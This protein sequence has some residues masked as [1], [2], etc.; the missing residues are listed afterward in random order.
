MPINT[1]SFA[2]ALWPGVNAWYGAEYAK[3][4]EEYLKLYEKNTSTRNY[5]EDVGQSG[6][7]LAV[8]KEEGS[9]V[10]YDTAR[11][12]F[13]TRY[14]HVTYGL[15]FIITREMYEDGLYDTYAKKRAENLAFSMR[16]TKEI[17]GASVYNKA[18]DATQVGG[19]GVVLLS[20]AHPN[21]AGGT[22]SNRLAVD[23]DLSEAALE[24]ACIDIAD[25]R[26]DRGLLIAVKPK[27]LI[28]PPELE[29]EAARILKTVGRVGTDLNDINALKEMSKFPGGVVVNHYL[30]D[31]DAWFI[32]T[33]VKDGMKYFSRRDDEFD[34]ENDFDT[35]NAKFKATF[36]CS[37]GWSD[38][39]GIYGSPGA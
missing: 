5:E 35:E 31:A 17:L 34:T 25:F 2:K 21:V 9:G 3:Y 4:A 7:G 1:G 36:R 13:T 20:T 39:R 8:I 38:A 14:R 11:Q 22:W 26:D 6:F 33:D 27:M 37:F 10:S 16:Q 28:I 30:T 12:G 18:T 19:D 23:S 32:R 24:Q 15:G 29:F